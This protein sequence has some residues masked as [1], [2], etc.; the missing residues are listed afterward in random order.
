[1]AS[2]CGSLEIER[3]ASSV[4]NGCLGDLNFNS[5]QWALMFG[6]NER[7]YDLDNKHYWGYPFIQAMNGKGMDQ[8]IPRS[9]RISDSDMHPNELG[10]ELIARRYYEQYAKVYS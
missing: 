9:H 3:Y 10:H 4:A 5:I 1:M 2:L 6:N 8:F 7:L